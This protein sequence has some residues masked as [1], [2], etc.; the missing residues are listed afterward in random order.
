MSHRSS[1]PPARSSG[2]PYGHHRGLGGSNHDRRLEHLLERMPRYAVSSYCARHRVT[3]RSPRRRR[4]GSTTGSSRAAAAATTSRLHRV[5]RASRC[6][7]ASSRLLEDR[8][9]DARLERSRVR[10]YAASG[11]T[12]ALQ[13]LRVSQVALEVLDQAAPAA[14]VS[15]AAVEVLKQRPVTTFVGVS[16]V[17]V[18]VL[19][20]VARRARFYAQIV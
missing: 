15:Q 19:V 16:Q 12:G 2:F 9:A 8:L 14:R 7:S 11:F 13:P 10:A 18:E 17:A 1:S 20:P 5:G 6:T 4:S 3:S